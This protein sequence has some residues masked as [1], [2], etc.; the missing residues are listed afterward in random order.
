MKYTK[1][2]VVFSVLLLLIAILVQSNP[3]L[4]N[5]VTYPVQSFEDPFSQ[6][7]KS[8]H[9]LH[10]NNIQTILQ[11]NDQLYN[12]I[13]DAL[14]NLKDEIN[15]SSYSLNSS[16][17]FDTR[18]KV[19]DNHPEIFYFTNSGSLFYS[20]GRLLFK[21]TYSKNEVLVMK[22]NL[23]NKITQ[24]ISNLIVG[25][26]SQFE[27]ELALHNYIILNSEYDYANY[28]NN[29]VP[30]LSYTAYGILVNGIGVCDGY[31]KAVN[32]LLNKVGIECILWALTLTDIKV[33][34][35]SCLLCRF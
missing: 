11:N 30:G 13:Y 23:E 26:Q 32:L 9:Q 20:N 15:V 4:A 12:A 31:A 18:N 25:G 21:Y 22:Q 8:H 27:M 2:V 6:F 5:E 7:G 17:V 35:F 16:E 34:V 24:I 33:S 14:A 28:K 10:S 3:V 29:T 1:I 19:L